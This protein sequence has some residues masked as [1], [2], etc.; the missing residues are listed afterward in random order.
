[1]Q[2]PA[3]VFITG[4]NGF[5]GRAIADRFRALG[6][7]VVGVDLNARWRMR[8]CAGEGNT[9]TG[10]PALVVCLARQ[11]WRLRALRCEASAGRVAP[12]PCLTLGNSPHPDKWS[13]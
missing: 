1:M 7:G 2:I 3:K 12:M 5:I 4:A 11:A 9:R 10:R 13:P 6:S 8:A